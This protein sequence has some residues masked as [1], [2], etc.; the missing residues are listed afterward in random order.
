[1]KRKGKGKMFELRRFRVEVVQ[2]LMR[3][4]KEQHFYSV[5]FDLPRLGCIKSTFKKSITEIYHFSLLLQNQHY[6]RRHYQ[7]QQVLSNLLP[8]NLSILLIYDL[9]QRVNM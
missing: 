4:G 7:V 5:V 2:K 1:M 8:E 3:E 9:Q 6:P